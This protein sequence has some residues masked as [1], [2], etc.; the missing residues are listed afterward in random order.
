MKFARSGEDVVS[1]GDYRLSAIGY[2]LSPFL[3]SCRL[4]MKKEGW[5]AHYTPLARGSPRA[6]PAMGAQARAGSW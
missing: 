1:A 6:L 2:R 5:R 4:L 3:P